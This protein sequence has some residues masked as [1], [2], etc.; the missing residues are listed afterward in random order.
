MK[1]R[2]TK[3]AEV[4]ELKGLL[5]GTPHV[6]L[7][8]FEK[9]TVGQDFKLRKTVRNAGG[10]YKVVKNTLAGIACEGT[11]AEPILKG[12]GGMN[13]IA[14]TKNDPVALA[15]ALRDFA[16]E[17]PTFSFK[18]GVVDG[19]VFQAK[20][21]EALAAMPPKEEIYAKLLY[22]IQAPAQQLVTVMN[23]VGRNLAV[24]VDQ[25]VK[26]NKFQD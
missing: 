3:A 25:G 26:E 12:L 20:D 1:T 21:V 24:V 6:F 9:L 5:A 14:F 16:K 7:A 8:T 13:S 19:Q 2:A 23:A 15:K 10:L 18:G 11:P 17:T 22:V 4:T